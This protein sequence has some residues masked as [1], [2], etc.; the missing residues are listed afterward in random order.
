M[1]R[2]Y[3]RYSGILTAAFLAAVSGLG[4]SGCTKNTITDPLP[5]LESVMG[6]EGESKPADTDASELVTRGNS[7]TMV[8]A[9]SRL[10][11]KYRNAIWSLSKD[12]DRLEELISFDD[13]VENA[14]I[15]VYNNVLYYNTAEMD[16]QWKYSLYKMDLSTKEKELISGLSEQTASLYAFD[17]ILYVKGSG[18]VQAFSLKEDGG[19]EAEKPLDE[20]IYGSIPEDAKELYGEPLPYLVESCGY[21]P[22]TNGENLVIAD[23]DGK[24]VRNV[25]EVTNTSMVLFAEDAF[26]AIEQEEES[27]YVCKRFDLT[28]LQGETLFETDQ[29]PSLMQYKNGSLYYL[30]SGSYSLVGQNSS[31]Y[32]MDVKT[33]E[34]TLAAEIPAEPGTAGFCSYY[35]NFYVTDGGIYCQTVKDYGVYMERTS[36]TEPPQQTLLNFP[37][38]Q[39][40]IKELGTVEGETKKVDSSDGSK[41]VAEIYVEKLVFSGNSQAAEA[42]NQV[43]EEAAKT[44]MDYGSQMV[45]PADESWISD[46]YFHESTLTYQISDVTYLDAG[47]CCIEATGYEY[48]GGAHGMPF[49]NYYI[50]DRK[51]GQRLSLSDI[52]NTPESELKTLVSAA[53]RAESERTAFSFDSPENLEKTV[54][55]GVSYDSPFYITEQGMVFFYTPYE[56][57]SY[58]AGFPEVTIPYEQLDL[59]IDIGK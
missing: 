9:G 58:A 19:I 32:R 49:K 52:L 46:E 59:K 28:T 37:L 13:G 40:E 18:S 36:L 11:F 56:I 7:D 22:L 51:T 26:Y 20:T 25:P 6:S 8:E 3:Y 33:K 14:A 5:T 15:W 43:M 4:L 48:S 41:T 30:E 16:G 45:D 24:N 10:Y 17:G 29:Y 34:K 2:H 23:K 42:M 39:S 50:F 27:L 44:E 55:E 47:Y 53:F 31:F 12:D 21:M 54:A 57:A 35:G 38:Y 1:K